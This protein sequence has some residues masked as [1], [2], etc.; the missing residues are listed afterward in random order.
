VYLTNVS[1]FIF[2][3]GVIS[4]LDGD[5]QTIPGWQNRAFANIVRP[6][7]PQ[8]VEVMFVQLAFT[9]L[10]LPSLFGRDRSI[11]TEKEEGSTEESIS[12]SLSPSS[13]TSNNGLSMLPLQLQSRYKTQ[14][15]PR[16]LKLA[17]KKP[18]K[19]EV[20]SEESNT[21]I[22]REAKSESD[23]KE[24]LSLSSPTHSDESSDTRNEL[25]SPR[26][27][28][29]QEAV[30]QNEEVIDHSDTAPNT[31]N[32]FDDRKPVDIEPESSKPYQQ[33]S[34]LKQENNHITKTA[35]EEKY[36]HAN[37]YKTKHNSRTANDIPAKEI[38][39][40]IKRKKSRTPS[41][42]A[43]VR[44]NED[45]RSERAKTPQWFDDDDG[46]DYASTFSSRLGPINMSSSSNVRRQDC[47]IV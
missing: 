3:Q 11:R 17:E 14:P 12:P 35:K 22:L 26:D 29:S 30:E 16:F 4:L 25:N 10:R 34:S 38:D 9:P 19:A 45:N 47:L 13:S 1:F 32:R 7:I 6:I 20:K 8:R 2:V 43:N 33:S 27:A 5:T 18:I 40:A 15:P 44:T 24:D 36:N 31:N 37:T 41:E 23:V 21:E 42:N 28:I 39:K 46:D